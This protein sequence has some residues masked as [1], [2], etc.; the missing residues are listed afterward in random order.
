MKFKKAVGALSA[1]AITVSAF[2][3]M[4][5]TA[6]ADSTVN[7]TLIHTA[8]TPSGKAAVEK[9]NTVDAETEY[10]NND[11]YN[12]D[13]GSGWY[14]FAFAQFDFDIP[15][16]ENIQSATLTWTASTTGTARNHT[17]YYLNKDITVPFETLEEEQVATNNYRYNGDR[18]FVETVNF[19]GEK[20]TVT[21]VTDAIK[22]LNDEGQNYV[23]FQ[24][25]NNAG[26]G[27]LYGMGSTEK[28]PRLEIQTSSANVYT[29][30]F[31][32][33]GDTSTETVVENDSLKDVPSVSNYVSVDDRAEYTFSGW[34]DGSTT[35]T[36]D[37]VKALPITK[38][39]TLTAVFNKLPWD[40]DVLYKN[41]V[42]PYNFTNSRGDS[43]SIG[44]GVGD[45]YS[46]AVDVSMKY[47]GDKTPQTSVVFQN[48]NGA[49][50]AGLFYTHSDLGGSNNTYAPA[51][52]F[53][54][55]GDHSNAENGLSLD[56]IGEGNYKEIVAEN[57][58]NP[59][60]INALFEV[61]Q[62][63]DTPT[64]TLHYNG[65]EYV[66]PLN[67]KATSIQSIKYGGFRYNNGSI[68][69]IIVK[70][71]TPEVPEP[72]EPSVNKAVTKV[73]ESTD[74]EGNDAVSY[75]AKFDITGSYEVK[76]VKWTV[77]GAGDYSGNAQTVD[78][79]FENSTTIT[80]GSIV[81]GLAIEAVDGL[82]TIGDVDAE[83]Q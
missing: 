26:G 68:R 59:E 7:A 41:T 65:S 74:L 61:N 76:G 30:T 67:N 52:Y 81:F 58:T 82:N 31:D 9:T 1:L 55:N 57:T 48:E 46:M 5:V 75:M 54:T 77:N 15:D 33:N 45:S 34:S 18:T 6:N 19:G 23:I 16:N 71:I 47:I 35:Y 70:D 14:S 3:G 29:V 21:D 17:I 78:N 11:G 25:T 51:I 27:S 44:V 42:L 53:F 32:I 66:L 83:L 36:N 38:D 2:A 24:W 72:V 64:V 8:S 56:K 43:R 63:G 37:E 73:L 13:L 22:T 10:Y 80:D 40:D 60:T 20:T 69:N 4:A 12:S 62:S 28:A 79:I 49:T 39:I 50:I